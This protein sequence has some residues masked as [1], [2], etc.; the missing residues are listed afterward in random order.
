MVRRW[1]AMFQISAEV[2]DGHGGRFDVG[3]LRDYPCNDGYD[4]R[5]ELSIQ[6]RGD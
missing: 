1:V 5:I 2:C 4:M 3:I 6:S